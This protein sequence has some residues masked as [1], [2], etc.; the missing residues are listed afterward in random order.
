MRNDF[1]LSVCVPAFNEEANINK[2]VQD[3]I[4]CLSKSLEKFEIIIV[5][6]GSRDSTSKI[7]NDLAKKHNEIKIIVHMKN[8]GIGSCYRDALSI[9][10]GDYFTWFPADCEDPVEALSSCLPYL[11]KD[12]ILTTYHPDV[13]SRSQ[14]R[15]SL[16]RVYTLILNGYFK[17]GLKYY[18]G[19]N[20]V[21]TQVVRGL[22]LLS[23]GFFCNAEIVIRGAQNGKRILEIATPLGRRSSGRSKALSC[24]SLLRAA[25]DLMKILS[26]RSR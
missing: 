5:D 4:H 19:L 21:P 23:D 9:A 15:R 16:S 18:N 26:Q 22:N 11:D 24:G 3:L 25:R 20:I 13:G 2:S 10:Q 1:V 7:A 17:L 8:S 14:F 12:T 6:D